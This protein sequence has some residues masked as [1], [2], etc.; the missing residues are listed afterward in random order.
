MAAEL[1]SGFQ[2]N[3]S[4]VLDVQQ[5]NPEETHGGLVSIN[6]S[7]TW[8]LGCSIDTKPNRSAYSF[9][10]AKVPFN[11]SLFTLRYTVKLLFLSKNN[12]ERQEQWI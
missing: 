8:K 7:L 12:F 5:K 2:H 11:C 10:K 4:C 6:H 9:L 3:I 1:L